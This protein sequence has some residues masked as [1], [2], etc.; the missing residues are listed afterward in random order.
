MT[1]LTENDLR[2]AIQAKSDQINAD[3]L[4]GGP[5]VCQ[6][7]DVR[8]GSA[9][10]PVHILVDSHKQPWKPSKT[11]LRVLAAC[12]GAD[13][14]VWVGRYAVLYNDETVKWAG[15]AVGGIRTSHLSHID[16]VKK[17]A[18]NE[19]RGKKSIQTVHPYVPEGFDQ[20]QQEPQ[21]YPDDR[22]EANSP[23]W[24]EAILSG[25]KT[26]QQVVKS[27][28]S[29]GVLLTRGQK[30]RLAAMSVKQDVGGEQDDPMQEAPPAMDDPFAS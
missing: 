30:D 4:S 13:P 3:D 29:R 26:L 24:A 28:E 22:F 18:V 12:W 8:R 27:V 5:L 19:T 23:K 21:Y 15:N 25:S 16:G 2:G 11:S 17:I 7:V 20:P 1:N 10:Q 14:S 9:D 6:I